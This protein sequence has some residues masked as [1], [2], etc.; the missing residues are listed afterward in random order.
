ML[1]ALKQKSNL[2]SMWLKP[3]WALASVVKWLEHQPMY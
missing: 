1:I 3:F 2:A